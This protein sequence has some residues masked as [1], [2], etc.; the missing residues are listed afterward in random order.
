MIINPSTGSISRASFSYKSNNPPDAPTINF[1]GKSGGLYCFLVS[2]TDPDGDYVSYIMV[3]GDRTLNVT[4]FF[5]SGVQVEI[6]HKF[7]PGH[8]IL[9]FRAKD[10]YDA[11]SDWSDIEINIPR[12]SAKL[13]TLFHWLLKRYLMLEI[14]LNFLG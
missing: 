2:S 10:I 6:C 4:D 1:S 14:M 11:E 7:W 3:M 8:Y 13:Y 12:T 5:P 9:Y